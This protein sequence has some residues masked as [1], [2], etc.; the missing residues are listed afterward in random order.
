M[1]GGNESLCR[2]R[3]SA[4]LG[5]VGHDTEE[6]PIRRAQ[7]G[8]RGRASEYFEL[9]SEEDDLQL[10]VLLDLKNRRQN[11]R[12][13]LSIRASVRLVDTQIQTSK[14]S[15]DSIFWARMEF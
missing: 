5:I 13:G 15:S 6:G 2:A 11:E 3:H 8:S 7:S 1:F 10:K 9:F 14:S 12:K 4:G